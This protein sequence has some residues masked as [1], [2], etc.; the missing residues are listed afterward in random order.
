MTTAE[1]LCKVRIWIAI[2][3]LY[4]RL[5]SVIAH[6]HHNMYCYYLVFWYFYKLYVNS[7]ALHI[8]FSSHVYQFKL[9][10]MHNDCRLL[11]LPYAISVD[12][13]SQWGNIEV[14]LNQLQTYLHT[15]II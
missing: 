11:L 13:S 10:T 7:A 15:T 5:S 8:C 12:R 3:S 14:G 4:V 1:D 9:E 6:V 2:T